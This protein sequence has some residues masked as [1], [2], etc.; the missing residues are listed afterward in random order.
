MRPLSAVEK[1]R[2]SEGLAVLDTVRAAARPAAWQA[3]G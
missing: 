1:I 3:A 2:S